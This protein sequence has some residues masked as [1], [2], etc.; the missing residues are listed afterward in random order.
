MAVVYCGVFFHFFVGIDR[1]FLFFF[2]IIIILRSH[3]AIIYNY[4]F[5]YCIYW[6]LLLLSFFFSCCW[7]RVAC[8]WEWWFL[9]LL[10]IL[11]MDTINEIHRRRNKIK[12]GRTNSFISPS[13]AAARNACIVYHVDS[14]RIEFRLIIIERWRKEKE[15]K[16]IIITKKKKKDGDH[17]YIICACSVEICACER[18]KIK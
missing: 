18:K 4:F 10:F 6:L 1:L 17:I 7:D 9:E 14:S 3:K 11:I 12:R 5:F 15:I 13:V 16:K 2:F 8:V